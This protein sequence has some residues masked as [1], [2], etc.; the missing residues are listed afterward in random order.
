MEIRCEK[1]GSTNIVKGKLVASGGVSFIPDSE[2]GIV[3][4]SAGVM[5]CACNDCG[6]IFNLRLEKQIKT[7]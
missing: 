3:K 2:K 7:K 6:C 4:Q 5:C 1:C